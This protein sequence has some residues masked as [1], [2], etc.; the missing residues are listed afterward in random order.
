MRLLPLAA[1]L[2]ILPF[3]GTVT[4]RLLALAAG[5]IVCAWSWHKEGF[6]QIPAQAALL[7]WSG[8]ALLSLLGAV[9]PGYSLGEIKNEIAY[10]MAA[11]F[12][13][14]TLSRTQA[15]VAFLLK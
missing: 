5:L 6:P 10:T 8:C 9:D 3:P 11:Y 13:F 4:L 2:F 7:F 1:F 15:D 14:V 12:V